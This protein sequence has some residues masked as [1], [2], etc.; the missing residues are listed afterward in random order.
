M[1]TV[2]GKALNHSLIQSLLIIS[3]INIFNLCK[4][5]SHGFI[6]FYT[7]VKTGYGCLSLIYL[8]ILFLSA[9]SEFDF[10]LHHIQ[11]LIYISNSLVCAFRL[12]LFVLFI[13][14]KMHFSIH[15]YFLCFVFC[16]SGRRLKNVLSNLNHYEITVPVLL[17]GK[18]HQPISYLFSHVSKQ[19]SWG[20]K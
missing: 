14:L 12:N 16:F 13:D 4:I 10:C 7:L 15:I 3:L 6:T 19:R 18:G 1:Y 11:I 8:N 5:T 9:W 2:K 17:D 20:G